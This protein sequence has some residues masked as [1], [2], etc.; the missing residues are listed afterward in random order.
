MP[1]EEVFDICEK[2]WRLNQARRNWDDHNNGYGK[3]IKQLLDEGA[4]V[5]DIS[6]MFSI[7]PSAIRKVAKEH[8]YK[9]KYKY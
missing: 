9:I 7:E 2:T 5:T 4:S 8:G 3:S 6:E 1:L